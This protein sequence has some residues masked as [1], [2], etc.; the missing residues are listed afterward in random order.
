MLFLGVVGSAGA[1][2]TV[3]S[4]LR[5]RAN[6]YVRCNSACSAFQSARP[7]GAGL[8]IPSDGVITRWRVRAATLGK[9]RLRI[10]RV[11]AD[12]SYTSVAAGDFVA[13]DRPHSPGQDVLYEFPVR[14]PVHEGDTIGLDRDA[15]AGGIFHTYGTNSTYAADEFAPALEDDATG[16]KPT[17][18]EAGRELLLNVDVEKDADGDGFGDETQDNCP[19]VANDQTDKPC[20]TATPTPASPGGPTSTPVT[21]TPPTSTGSAGPP[22][23]GERELQRDKRRHSKRRGA[24]RAPGSP[25]DPTRAHSRRNGPRAAPPQTS[26]D[27]AGRHNTKPEPRA[28]PRARKQPTSGHAPTSRRPNPPAKRAPSGDTHTRTSPRPKPAPRRT[29]EVRRHRRRAARPAPQPQPAP[30]WQQHTA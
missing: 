3:G 18:T 24:R 17:S 20:T 21:T 11:D 28:K 23:Q 4:S 13:L 14:I 30:G 26:P 15:K 8:R 5:Q 29:A 2:T 27:E 9:V 1:V 16:V 22:V 6:L 7:G 25:S 10:V 12:G 19:T